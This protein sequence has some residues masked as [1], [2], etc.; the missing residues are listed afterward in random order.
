MEHY[1]VV[2][3]ALSEG[4]EVLAGFWGV[5]VVEFNGDDTLGQVS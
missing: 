3:A 2:V 4:R 1:A 5:V